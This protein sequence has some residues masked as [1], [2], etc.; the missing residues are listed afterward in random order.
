MQKLE[1]S[2]NVNKILCFEGN[3]ALLSVLGRQWEVFGMRSGS[4]RDALIR[5]KSVI[6]P[7]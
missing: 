5:N 7:Y 6:S 1:I 3:L 4:V 2:K